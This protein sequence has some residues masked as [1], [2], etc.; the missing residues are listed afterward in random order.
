MVEGKPQFYQ[1]MVENKFWGG[2][3]IWTQPDE[4]QPNMIEDKLGDIMEYE[5]F[6][7]VKAYFNPTW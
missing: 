5:R 1:N 3:Q 4:F 7:W 6:L 2:T